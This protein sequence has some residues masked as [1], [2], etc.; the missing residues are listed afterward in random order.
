MRLKEFNECA[1][2]AAENALKPCVHIE[3]WI[4]HLVNKRPFDHVEQLYQ[5]ANQQAKNWQWSE[6]AQALAQHPRIGERKAVKALSVK[7][8]QFSANEQDGLGND[9][10]IQQEILL[11]NIAYEQRF[12]YIFLIRAAGRSA[13]DILKELQRRI[14]NSAEQEQQEAS[15]QLAEI[16]LLRL[17]QE[18]VA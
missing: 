10:T 17:K 15:A 11:G 3:S 16:A 1:V 13:D 4:Q 6:V 12:G 8:Q 9:Q 18:I 5:A 2:S 7:E 14:R